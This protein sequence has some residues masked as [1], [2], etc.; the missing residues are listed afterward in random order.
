VA[1]A[2]SHPDGSYGVHRG[3]L[4]P[5]VS[6]SGRVWLQGIEN[7]SSKLAA[8]AKIDIDTQLASGSVDERNDAKFLVS[9][10]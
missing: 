2:L 8:V 6:D 10:S 1:G 4:D 9:P 3:V 5:A 7:A